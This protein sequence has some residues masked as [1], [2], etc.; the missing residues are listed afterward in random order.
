[1]RKHESRGGLASLWLGLVAAAC[2]PAF[3]EL[4]TPTRAAPEGQPSAPAAA[5]AVPLTTIQPSP[6]LS[7]AVVWAQEQLEV[8]QP[9]GIS[10]M[11]VA[12]LPADQRGIA[13]SGK[14]TLLGS[15]TWVEIYLPDGGFGWVNSWNLTE[16]VPAQDFCAD[17]RP[18]DLANRFILAIQARNGAQLAQLASPKRGLIVRHDWWNPEVIFGSGELARLF[19]DRTLLNWGVNR[20]SGLAI[21]GSFDEV[22]LPQLE[23]VFTV[24]P[25]FSCNSLAAGT[26]A[27]EAIWPPEYEN[28]NY[29]SFHREAPVAGSLNWRTWALGIEYVDGRPYLAVLV[30]YRGEI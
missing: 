13:V 7:Y 16:E 11:A 10:S 21:E 22:I 5:S 17:P 1:M 12:N 23:D 8:R 15:S 18:T 30:Q 20:D 28:L 3:V 6:E 14:T 27:Q 19:Q 9:A 25:A 29:I 4:A 26:T 24:A 2:R